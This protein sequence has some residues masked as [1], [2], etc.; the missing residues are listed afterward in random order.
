MTEPAASG[1]GRR[2]SQPGALSLSRVLYFLSDAAAEI[3]GSA[4]D[5]DLGLDRRLGERL[6]V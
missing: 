6:H 2:G 1:T 4:M 5:I 3:T